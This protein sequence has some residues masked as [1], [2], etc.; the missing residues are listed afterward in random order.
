MTKTVD[1]I[2]L[3]TWFMDREL[4]Y[5]PIHFVPVRT[6]ITPE[7]REWILEK[8][9]GRFAVVI[10]PNFSVINTSFP[11]TYPAFEDPKEAVFYELTWS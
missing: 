11:S 7:S 5:V 1:D 2:N 8:L 10:D 6:P 4:D 3:N 9:Q